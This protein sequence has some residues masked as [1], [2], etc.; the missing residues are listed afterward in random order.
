MLPLHLINPVH[1]INNHTHIHN[2]L[3]TWKNL[4]C[5]QMATVEMTW[6]VLMCYALVICR[7]TQHVIA[8]WDNTA[9]KC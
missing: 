5:V 3:I 6:L 8:L 2:S 1:T 7:N 9:N 4:P